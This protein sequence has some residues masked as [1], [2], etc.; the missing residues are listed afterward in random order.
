MP[1]FYTL[2]FV[3][4]SELIT[5]VMIVAVTFIAIVVVWRLYAGYYPGSTYIVTEPPIAHNGLDPKQARFMFFYTT[6]CPYC[7]EARKKWASFKQTLINNPTL[8]GGYQILFEDVNA[9]ADRGKSSLY[10]IKAYPTFKLETTD[11]VYELKG[12]RFDE[13]LVSVLGKK[14]SH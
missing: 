9:E 11:K 1:N 13:F 3:R 8:Y 5:T 4:M 12:Q 6:W 14:T 7:I 2:H 10:Q